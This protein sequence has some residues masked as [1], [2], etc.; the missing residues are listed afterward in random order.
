MIED[1][2]HRA[3]TD[4]GVEIAGRVHGDDPP[5]VFVHGALGDGE[6]A[7]EPLLPLL[8]PPVHVT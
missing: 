1:R 7:E 4:D 6:T 3:T 2:I 5:L 8:T